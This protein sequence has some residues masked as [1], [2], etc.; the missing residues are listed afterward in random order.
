MPKDP[1]DKVMVI[2]PGHLHKSVELYTGHAF[3]EDGEQLFGVRLAGASCNHDFC[4][5]GTPEFV[6]SVA[7]GILIAALAE[8]DAREQPD[9]KPEPTKQQ[10]RDADC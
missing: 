9:A 4:F 1:E 2:G 5:G 7:N 6:A 8:I 3:T 10:V